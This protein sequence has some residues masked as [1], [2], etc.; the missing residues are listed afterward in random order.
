MRPQGEVSLEGLME[1]AADGPPEAQERLADALLGAWVWA[2]LP[3]GRVDPPERWLDDVIRR[4]Q[5]VA[6]LSARGPSGMLFVPVFTDEKRAAPTGYR[7]LPLSRVPFVLV[8]R[9]AILIG[10]E[11]VVV[12]PGTVPMT[13]VG[14]PALHRLAQGRLA[15]AG[16][17]PSRIDPRALRFTGV[18]PGGF[19]RSLQQ[20]VQERLVEDPNVVA[21]YMSGSTS[22]LSL[23]PLSRTLTPLN[24]WSRRR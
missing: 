20:A 8:A 18:P 24:T 7:D 5:G 21:A 3:P 2:A 1:A 4:R 12:N 19:R 11:A 17:G 6:I 10:S 22:R 23:E 15:E 13:V 16:E 9:A 14:N